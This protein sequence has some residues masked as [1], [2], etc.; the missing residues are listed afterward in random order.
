MKELLN[1]RTALLKAHLVAS[2]EQRNS[3]ICQVKQS[4]YTLYNRL[5]L[6]DKLRSFTK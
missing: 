1:M 5:P 2:Q 6:H 4:P 3:G